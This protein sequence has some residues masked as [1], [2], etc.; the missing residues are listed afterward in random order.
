MKGVT[1]ADLTR[2]WTRIYTLGLPA[3]LKH[4]RRAEIDADLWDS[5]HDHDPQPQIASR[6]LIGATDDVAWR[7]GQITL[8]TRAALLQFAA[9][10]LGLATLW[11]WLAS[12]PESAVIRDSVWAYPVI[13]SL[14]VLGLCLFLGLTVMLDLRLVGL[15]LRTV[16]VSAIVG[17]I[18]PWAV[19]GAAIAVVTGM[20]AFTADPTRFNHNVFF[21]IKGIAVAIAVLNT[22]IFHAFTYRGAREWDLWPVPPLQ[23]RIAGY[24]SLTL[25]ATVVVTGRFIAYA[26]F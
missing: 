20:L 6:L 23:A 8:H 3:D 10:A 13:E 5:Q 9:G 25:W 1:A 21:Q 22:W 14:H 11:L 4:A 26:W 2:L 7:M 17:R 24:V 16:P 15:T 18:M 19:L 12:A